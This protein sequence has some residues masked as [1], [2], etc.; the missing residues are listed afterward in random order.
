MIFGMN[1][2]LRMCH[3][4]HHPPHLKFRWSSWSALW[5]RLYAPDFF[6]SISKSHIFHFRELL[7]KFSDTRV[8]FRQFS[9]KTLHFCPCT[10]FFY[11]NFFECIFMQSFHVFSHTYVVFGSFTDI[12]MQNRFLRFLWYHQKTHKI[13][14][15]FNFLW[16]YWKKMC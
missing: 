8:I 1:I 12:N 16:F 7:L 15:F 13:T 10:Y 14:I 5:V 3:Y 11:K 6:I 4:I 9:L 2:P